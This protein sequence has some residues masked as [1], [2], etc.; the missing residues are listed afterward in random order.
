MTQQSAKLNADRDDEVDV[1]DPI[2]QK[3]Y[4]MPQAYPPRKSQVKLLA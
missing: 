1:Y 4:F 3:Q 2:K